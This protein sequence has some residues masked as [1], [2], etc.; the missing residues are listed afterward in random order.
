MVISRKSAS[1]NQTSDL[2]HYLKTKRQIYFIILKPIRD[3]QF[4]ILTDVKR[5]QP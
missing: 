3:L 5:T 1:E 4:I 2:P